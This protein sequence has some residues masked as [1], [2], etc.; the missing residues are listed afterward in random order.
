MKNSSDTIGNRT[1][2][3]PTCSAVPQ[4]NAP[5]RTPETRLIFLITELLYGLQMLKEFKLTNQ[6][7]NQPSSCRTSGVYLHMYGP[8]F[9]FK[10]GGQKLTT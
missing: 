7:T 4:P 8:R 3:L 2:D 9:D 5:P 1:R 10:A 6:E